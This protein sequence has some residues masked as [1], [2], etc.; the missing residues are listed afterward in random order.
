MSFLSRRLGNPV[1]S[2]DPLI[3]DSLV[4][5]AL[6]SPVGLFLEVLKILEHIGR[7][8]S[9][10]KIS[11]SVLSAEKSLSKRVHTA[12]TECFQVYFTHIMNLFTDKGVIIQQTVLQNS[13]S[14]VRR[15]AFV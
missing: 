4:D 7:K 9:A 1:S 12:H 2:L 14:Q 8:T 13:A 10:S 5:I 15:H 6:I 11:S 3:L